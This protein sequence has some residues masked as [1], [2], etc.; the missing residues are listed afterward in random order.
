MPD[1]LK[2]VLAEL[3]Q[4]PESVRQWHTAKTHLETLL[5]QLSKKPG[6]HAVTCRPANAIQFEE[7]RE[8]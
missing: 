6:I 1:K 8:L 5:D 4:K 7:P 3:S 2:R